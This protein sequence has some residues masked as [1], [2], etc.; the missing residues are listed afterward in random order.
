MITEL[1][2]YIFHQK[3][4]IDN[5]FCNKIIEELEDINFEKH[6]FYHPT[7]GDYIIR[8]GDQELSHSWE[9]TPSKNKLTKKLWNPINNYRKFLNMPWFD[10]WRG[11]TS[12]R[13]NKYELNKKMALHCDHIHDMFDGERKGVPILSVLGVLNNDFEGGEFIMFD[14]HEIKFDK[15]DVVIFPSNFLYPH[16]VE[17]VTKGTRYSYI[18]WVW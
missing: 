12:V 7:T 10:T 5:D 4:Y 11:Y 17:P 18:S 2:H 3:N 6:N 15:G 9:D 14:D 8:S 13:F 16:K 1:K